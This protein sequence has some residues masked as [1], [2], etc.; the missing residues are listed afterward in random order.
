MNGT[1]EIT[2][3]E[4]LN[5]RELRAIKQ[6][7]LIK[8]YKA[9]LI[10]FMVNIPGKYKDTPLI[11]KIHKEE[12]NIL[13]QILKKEC[14]P[15]IYE[16]AICKKTGPEGFVILEIDSIKVKR[17]LVQIENNHSLGRLFDYDVFDKEYNLITRASINK[18]RRKCF[19]CNEYASV[20]ARSRK[21]TYREL[22]FEINAIVLNYF[23]E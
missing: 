10:S 11:R 14:I 4:L 12:R 2:L 7:E 16:E 20:C 21:H 1:R 8:T 5:A 19:I 22:I 15:I 6:K 17:L 9:T 3:E 23:N 18:P 13:H